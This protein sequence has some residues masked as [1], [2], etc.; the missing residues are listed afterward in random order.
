MQLSLLCGHNHKAPWNVCPNNVKYI[1]VIA[2]NKEKRKAT[3]FIMNGRNCAGKI[4]NQMFFAIH[5]LDWHS[6]LKKNAW[7]FFPNLTQSIISLSIVNLV[8]GSTS[9][10]VH[11]CIVDYVRTVWIVCRKLL[12]PE[13]VTRNQTWP[14][15]YHSC[16][17]AL[18][19][20]AF[21]E[22]WPCSDTSVGI[23]CFPEASFSET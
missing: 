12:T 20:D 18:L 19:C 1:L 13:W 17:P 10:G 16:A 4:L 23:C 7:R 9:P 2:W 22:Y 8:T 3:H 6:K 11:F 15:S 21:W 5:C 14:P